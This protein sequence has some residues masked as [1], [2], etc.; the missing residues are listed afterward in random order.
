M[1][2]PCLRGAV[3]LVMGVCIQNLP[4][5]IQQIFSNLLVRALYKHV[6]I[7]YTMHTLFAVT[8]CEEE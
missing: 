5:N 2:A 3:K 4:A 1:D 6:V 7:S 8:I